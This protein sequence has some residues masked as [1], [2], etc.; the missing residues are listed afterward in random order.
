MIGTDIES[1]EHVSNSH[2]V[3]GLGLAPPWISFPCL[4]RSTG[5][6]PADSVE[7]HEGSSSITLSCDRI[8]LLRAASSPA[9]APEVVVAAD[10]VAAVR[11]S[12]ICPSCGYEPSTRAEAAHQRADLAVIWLHPDPGD[13][14]AVV[15]RSHCHQCEPAPPAFD[16]AC[17]VCSDGPILA[18][19][20]AQV[21]HTGDGFPD[22]VRRWLTAN[23]WAV[24][25][26]LRCPDHT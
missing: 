17:T 9:V 26:E 23:G 14:G 24:V 2:L 19:S 25:P 13:A 15:A 1:A 3:F 20:L 18:G 7:V 10:S 21:A 22:P 11:S 16:D 6:S 8:E 12:R 4:K 5:A